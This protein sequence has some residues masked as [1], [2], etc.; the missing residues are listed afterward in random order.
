MLNVIK[1][2]LASVLA[3]S[4]CN[5]STFALSSEKYCTEHNDAMAGGTCIT[6][7]EDN[8]LVIVGNL[9]DRICKQC[10]EVQCTLVD[11]CS[12]DCPSCPTEEKEKK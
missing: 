3:F 4:I 7:D 11:D 10:N 6:C 5:L 8:C 2:L 12:K 1:A 9:G